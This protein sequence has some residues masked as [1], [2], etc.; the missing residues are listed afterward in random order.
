MQVD[1]EDSSNGS[2]TG[3]QNLWLSWRFSL[4][5]RCYRFFSFMPNSSYVLW[6]S[7]TFITS[8]LVPIFHIVG[9][10]VAFNGLLNR[11]QGVVYLFANVS[12]WHILFMQVDYF[13]MIFG[14]N[15]RYDKFV[16]VFNC[17][18]HEIKQTFASSRYQWCNCTT[19][20]LHELT[21]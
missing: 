17:V 8:G 21:Q 3:V 13:P 5:T 19:I 9:I 14:A 12:T 18:W 4:W 15:S 16:F 20:S 1:F 11:C 7:A 10:S 6:Y 2:S